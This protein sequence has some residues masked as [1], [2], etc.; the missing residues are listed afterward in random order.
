MLIIRRRLILWLIREYVKKWRKTILLFF[1]AGLAVFFLMRY[2]FPY[3]YPK[4]SLGRSEST[5]IL[6]PYTLQNLP[7]S[8]LYEMSRGLTSISRDGS[9]LPDIASSWDIENNG[10]VYVF[11]L[12]KNIFYN[13]GSKLTSGSINYNFSDAKIERPDD[14]TIKFILKDNFSPFLVTVSRPIFKRGFIG[15]GEYKIYDVSV[16]G[17][18]VQSIRLVSVKNPYK[19]KIFQFYPST[20]SL[21]TAYLLGEVNKIAGLLDPTFE[22]QQFTTYPNTEVARKVN[23][24]LLVTLFYNTQDTVVSDKRIRQALSYAIPDTFSFGKKAYTP[25]P[26][27]SWAY[28]DQYGFKYDLE[29]A[30]LLLLAANAASNSASLKLHIKTFTKYRD[31]ALVVSK[32]W[33]KIGVKTTIES[34]DTIPSDFQIFLGDFIVPKDPDQYL[35]W[36]SNL[37]ANI[38]RYDDKRIDKLLEDGR[39][40]VDFASRKKIYADF[41]KY[42]LD[43]APASFLYFPYEYEISRR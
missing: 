33:E 34:V 8:I 3:F 2:S 4:L 24:N 23:E 40:S 36:H 43:G 25:Y 19:K 7:L 12:K 5:G 16:N 14:Y 39:K 15:V 17:N 30:K 6:G 31:T 42:L 41:Q 20:R 27:V 9:L 38:S 37:S 35:L 22:N 26:P 18:F 11:H 13:D 1:I 21:K 10:K 32:T 28:T 29:N